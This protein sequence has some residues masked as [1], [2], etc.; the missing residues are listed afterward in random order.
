MFS[1]VVVKNKTDEEIYLDLSKKVL[2]FIPEKL[3][4]L[5][6]KKGGIK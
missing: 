4:E 5:S 2:K 3:V 6:L 1:P